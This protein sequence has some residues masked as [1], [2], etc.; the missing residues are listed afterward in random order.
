VLKLIIEDDEGRK[1][2]VPFS[3]DEI[4]IGRQ[5]GNTIRLTERNVSRHHAR[6]LRQ[7]GQVLVEDLGSSNGVLI[8]G[9]RI[10]GQT[11]VGDGDLIQIGDYDLALQQEEMAQLGAPTVRVPVAPPQATLVE[12]PSRAVTAEP[13]TETEFPAHADEDIT[14]TPSPAGQRHHA[15]A[16]SRLDPVEMNPPHKASALDPKDA[17]YLVVV[18]AE[19]KGREFACVR[20]EVR[21][22]RTDDNDIVIDHRSLSRTHA[23]LVREDSGEWRI[24][25]LQSANGTAVNGESHAQAP[26]THG[27][28]LELGHVKLRFI[29]PGQG[30]D[31][32][33]NEKAATKGSNKKLVLALVGLV[34]LG[35]GAG[36]AWLLFGQP[37]TDTGTP[38]QPLVEK[39]P[40]Q[41]R[42]AP[43]PAAGTGTQPTDNAAR[44]T[45]KL[46]SARAAMDARDFDKAVSELQPLAD[47][48]T[49][50]GELLQ[51]AQAEQ[52]AKQNLD[53]AQ[54]AFDE[55]R[56]QEAQKYLEASEG[57]LAFAEEHAVLKQAV[58]TARAPPTRPSSNK[59]STGTARRSTT[60]QAR[61]LY[62]AGAALVRKQ[63]LPEAESV[64]KKCITLDPTYAPC[65]LVL[66]AAVARRNR[67]DEGAQ[68]YREFLRLAPNH[69]KAPSVRKLL[70]DYDK[71]QKQPGGGK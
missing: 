2:V 49:E 35:P 19:L 60:G 14:P 12:P 70:A 33:L 56:A 61:Q 59:H 8:N 15:T 4:T 21:I 47:S 45:E 3:R 18:S 20:T 40:E 22:G 68:Y 38:R 25:D 26:L 28:L 48:N 44:L 10:Q 27:D 37:P 65:Y 58:D 31:G 7:N 1:T 53:L 51:Q 55:G 23:R 11:R 43:Q 41:Q 42:Q 63:Q 36:A 64:L 54:K 34:L 67:L 62:D 52:Q 30:T 57:T 24:I 17:P 5:D 50:A 66:G 69:E 29:G 46:Q 9:E 6:L 39:A 13:K 71:S 32:L 16:V